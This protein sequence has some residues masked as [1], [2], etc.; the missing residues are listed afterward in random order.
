MTTSN[1]YLDG[2]GTR[3]T[4]R[5]SGGTKVCTFTGLAAGA[6]RISDQVDLGVW[7]HAGWYRWALETAWAANPVANETLDA[8]YSL[9]DNDTGP[10]ASWANLGASD[11]ALVATQRQNMNFMKPVVAETAGTA[12]CRG[13]GLVYL[14]ARY[15]TFGFWNSS[16]AK[17][18]A[19]VGTTPTIFSLT[20][21]ISQ[22]Q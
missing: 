4:I 9:W 10:A 6:G 3:I 2:S 8:Y 14:P 15:V 5:D 20:P 11:A 12:L 21:I 17:A 19:A 16:A 7:P 13:G 1:L 22:Q 18:L